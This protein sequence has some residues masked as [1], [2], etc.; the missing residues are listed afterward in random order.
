V[1]RGYT[2]FAI[3]T[4]IDEVARGVGA[5]PLAYRIDLLNKNPRGQA[6]LKAVAM[7][8]NR[9]VERQTPAG[10]AFADGVT[11]FELH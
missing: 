3:K 9:G 1:G 6:V 7:T 8:C 10:V 4:L 5:D 2:K 11:G